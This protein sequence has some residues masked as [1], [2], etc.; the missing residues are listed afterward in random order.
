MINPA[1][2]IGFGSGNSQPSPL[3]GKFNLN[4]PG[5]FNSASSGMSNPFLT[6]S[7]GSDPSNPNSFGNLANLGMAAGAGVPSNPGGSSAVGGGPISQSGSG[8]GSVQHMTTKQIQS[9]KHS[10]IQTTTTSTK[11]TTP[12]PTISTSQLQ[13]TRSGTC[14]PLRCTPPC[15]QGVVIAPD[16]CPMCLCQP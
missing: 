14:A 11:S 15:D 2:M 13:T 3:L 5:G 10:A 6:G 16:G 9:T 4:L 1:S 7:A 8:T 12:P